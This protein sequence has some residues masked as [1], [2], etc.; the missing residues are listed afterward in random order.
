MLA[1]KRNRKDRRWGRFLR[2]GGVVL[3][4]ALALVPGR[5]PS[6]PL[7]WQE[8]PR[9]RPDVLLVTIDTLRADY[10]GCY[11]SR[12]VSTPHLDALAR[13]G[14]RF[15]RAVSE[16]P[17]TLPAHSS[18][19]TGL[20]PLATGVRDN[21]G[22]V[23]SDRHLTLAEILKKEGY[24]TG[25]F[26]GAFVLDAKWGLAQGF[27]HYDDRL[28][29]PSGDASRASPAVE[30][31]AEEVGRAAR[32]WIRS[33]S[34]PEPFFCWIHLFDPH[35]PYEP[36][37]PFRAQYRTDPY[38][39]EVAYADHVLGQILDFLRELGRYENTL[40][41]VAGDHGE[42]LGEH[43]E[44][45]HG[46][47]LYDST[48][49]VPLI[50][51]P[52]LPARFPAPLQPQVDRTV[53]LVDV[54]PTL[55]QILELR[56]PGP[57]QGKGLLGAMLGKGAG[58]EPVAYSET[59]YP[60]EFG[61]S[62]LRALRTGRYKYILA[63]R[64]ELYDLLSD[65]EEQENLAGREAALANQFKSQLLE[66]ESRYGSRELDSEARVELSAEELERF[67]SLGYI[68]GPRRGRP[69]REPTLPDPKDKIGQYSLLSQA[70]TLIARR[71]FAAALPLLDRLRK[72]EPELAAVRS[73]L[74]QSY[75]QLG[76]YREAR[77][78][79]EPA[80]QA[81]PERIYPRLYLAEACFHLKDFS[82]AEAHFQ[83]LVQQDPLLFQAFHYL[84]LIYSDQGK[85]DQAIQAFSRAVGI[86]QD[87]HAYAMLG[88]L[89][90]KKNDPR[91]AARALEK[92][93]EL[94]PK[95]A[96][97]HLYLAN[98]Y[99][100]LGDQG[101]AQQAYRRAISLDPALADKLR[102]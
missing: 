6:A 61:W 62:E 91:E 101:K 16:V 34:R 2:A 71:Q 39:G 12:K 22:Y 43:G 15:T 52:P 9:L 85:T 30:R 26:V 36:P 40:I 63:P 74:G 32:E 55:L 102:R 98:A 3:L 8:A 41:V 58:E 24:R 78:I 66:L 96:L 82:S 67:R 23:L 28:A 37:E 45:T 4:G 53:Q 77:E 20:Y 94:D 99:F 19:L 51:R 33:Q 48:L 11:G 54:L 73:T 49:L 97:A 50:I 14:T 10:V 86:R 46:Y 35:D 5:A 44:Q 89:Y 27:D 83:K 47:F 90:T 92:T 56:P 13:E 87:V 64:P 93:V 88:Y 7:S 31:R 25:A 100:L 18:L 65:P 59:Y 70:M 81:E 21:L 29:P 84:G 79:L 60:N 17:L 1:G 72:K 95:N 42:A 69:S 76:R 68:G 57:V 80:V 38:A 75:L